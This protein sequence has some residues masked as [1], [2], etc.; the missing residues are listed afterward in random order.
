M[1]SCKSSCKVEV[2]QTWVN[3]SVPSPTLPLARPVRP[4]TLRCE[5]S[6]DPGV[7]GCLPLAACGHPT[8]LACWFSCSL[9]SQPCSPVHPTPSTGAQP[10]LTG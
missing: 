2:R 5:A 3:L 9:R 6:L 7:P 4:V 1:R 10:L 8:P